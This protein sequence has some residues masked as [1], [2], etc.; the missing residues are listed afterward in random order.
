MGA[1]AAAGAGAPGPGPAANGLARRA[2]P[3]GQQ[4]VEFVPQRHAGHGVPQDRVEGQGREQ[5]HARAPE[6]DGPHSRRHASRPKPPWTDIGIALPAKRA[7]S[8]AMN[9]QL[10]DAELFVRVARLGSLSAA[11]RERNV[12]V[13]Q[14]TRA[15]ARLEAACGAR[16]MHR[17]THGLSLTDEGDT[18]LAQAQ[19]LL[20][21]RDELQAEMTGR[22]TGPSGWVRVSVSAVLAQAVIA[23]GLAGLYERLPGLR[24]DISADDRIVDM[25]REGVDVAVRTGEPQVETLVRGASGISPAASMP[26]HPTWPL[27]ACRARWRTS[28]G[29]VSAPTAAAPA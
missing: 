27:T 25:A 20:D 9:L 21:I 10:D 29:T 22:V 2:G 4:G 17:N 13:S 1:A 14:V 18:F 3:P 6:R 28:P 7:E 23:P 11:A 12:A 5:L 15:L 8:V 16:L 24:L 19:R 26:R